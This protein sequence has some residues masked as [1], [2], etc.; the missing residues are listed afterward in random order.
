MYTSS[1]VYIGLAS[2]ICVFVTFALISYMSA[3]NSGSA[4]IK[5]KNAVSSTLGV[6]TLSA[7][8]LGIWILFSPPSSALFGG[9]ASVLGY[10]LA[11]ALPLFALAFL[12][13]RLRSVM[14]E[15]S[16]L[17]EYTEVKLGVAYKNL[18]LV[19]SIFYMFIF[20]CAEMTAVAKVLESYGSLSL[21]LGAFIILLSAVSYSLLGGL[22]LSIKTDMIQFV[23]IAFALALFF[24]VIPWHQSLAS[25]N[26]VEEVKKDFTNFNSVAFGLT[27]IIAVLCTEVFNHSTWQRVYAL[28]DEAVKKSFVISGSIVF[29][30]IFLLGLSGIFAKSTGLLGSDV[31]LAL[32]DLLNLSNPVMIV[33]LIILVVSLVLSSA[34]TLL[35]GIASLFILNKDED[36]K[37]LNLY[38]IMMIVTCFPVYYIASKGYDVFYMF[39]IADLICCA[40]IGPAIFAILGKKEYKK[41]F[42]VGIISLVVGA[43]LFPGVDFTDGILVRVLGGANEVNALFATNQL[44]FS[45]VITVFLSFSLTSLFSVKK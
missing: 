40:L 5:Y 20:L 32:F 25:I 45:F 17:I 12:G 36:S 15:A 24:Y 22:R 29:V 39:L 14:P 21:G 23:L 37:N 8:A 33:L 6:S 19:C 35:N 44:F 28:R 27:L 26:L 30:V 41:S 3:K 2:S 16:S 31:N 42:L 9:M 1:L 13:T 10:A 43:V 11:S 7:S 18:L 34:D 38:R 4:I